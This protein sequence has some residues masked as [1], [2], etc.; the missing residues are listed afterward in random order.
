MKRELIELI[1]KV[2]TFSMYH[3][4]RGSNERDAINIVTENTYQV[5][6]YSDYRSQQC[7]QRG[8]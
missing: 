8:N 2:N 7:S 3:K 6:I 4:N 5:P 1:N